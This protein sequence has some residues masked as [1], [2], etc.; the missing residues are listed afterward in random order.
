MNKR[1]KKLI[2]IVTP[3]YNEEKNYLELFDRINKTI[4]PFSS[5]YLFEIIAIDNN[6]TDKTRDILKKI[7]LNHKNFK[8]I[9]NQRNFGYIRSSF[10][11]VINAFGDAVILIASDLQ[12]PPEMISKYIKQWEDGNEVVLA[13]KPKSD[14]FF[15]MSFVRRIYYRLLQKISDSPLENDATGA[16]LYDKKVVDQLRSIR[17]PYPYL[18]GLVCDLGFKRSTVEFRQPKRSKG[19]S[20][21]NLYILLDQALQAMT[22]HSKVPIRALTIFG[23]LLSA[24]SISI[25]FIYLCLKLI[26]WDSFSL[27]I[28]PMLISLF[29]FFGILFFF[30][31]IL[32]EYLGMV[33]TH[34]R[35]MPLVIEKQRINF[36]NKKNI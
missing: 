15:I 1:N 4:K 28:A 20:S 3:T 31:G 35:D 11:G 16:G 33:L 18:R 19:K 14:E 8:C 7:A 29:F 24:G 26:Y 30:L 22:K 13:V 6:S 10:Y 5:N 2:S 17:D 32:G 12:D 25:S 36:E 27:G 9:F 34:I 21:T 23:F